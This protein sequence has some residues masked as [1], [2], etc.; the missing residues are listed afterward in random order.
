MEVATPHRLYHLSQ[1]VLSG[2]DVPT[3][4]QQEL[5][6]VLSTVVTQVLHLKVD[7]A[8]K[9]F[10]RVKEEMATWGPVLILSAE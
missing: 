1:L 6:W 8:T 9:D 4:A 2:V 5:G 3:E 10:T 7:N